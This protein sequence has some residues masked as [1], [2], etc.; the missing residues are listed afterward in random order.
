MEKSAPLLVAN[1]ACSF[2]RIIAIYTVATFI[3]LLVSSQNTLAKPH[4]V[5]P[6]NTYCNPMNLDYAFV[7]YRDYSANNNDHR[8]TADPACVLHDG[9]YYLFSTNQEG[10]WWSDDLTRWHFISHFFKANVTGDQVCAPAVLSTR[11]GLLFLPCRTDV[12]FDSMP[13]YLSKNPRSG[14]WKEEVEQFPVQAW[15]PGLFQDNDGRIYLYWGSSNVYPIYGAELDPNKGYIARGPIHELLKLDPVKHGWERFGEDNINGKMDPFIEGAWMNKFGKRYYLQYAAPGT[16]WNVYGDGVYV[17]EHPLGPFTYQSH[18]PF[19]WKPTGFVRGAGH[20]CTFADKYGNLWHIATMVVNVKYTCERRLGLFPAGVDKDGV[21][22][23]DTAFGDY[24]HFI[25]KKRVDP[26]DNF[27]GWF[28]LSYKKKSWASSGKDMVEKA[29]DEDIKTYWSADNGQPGQY[30]AVDLGKEVDVNAI[31]INYAD[32]GA[33]T[34]GKQLDARHRYQIFH[35]LNGRDWILLVDKSANKKEVPHDY[36]E[37]SSAQRTRFLKIVNVE[38]PTGCFALSDFR[39]FGKAP[40]VQAEP[41]S[42]FTALRDSQD[43]RDLRL[44]WKPT[45]KATCYEVSFG[46][47]Q[48]KLYSSFLVYDKNSYDLHGLNVDSSYFFRIRSVSE[49]GLSQYSSAAFVK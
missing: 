11:R 42:E 16:E 7:P 34:Y 10:Y 35:S 3:A 13:L 5:D 44:S 25:P 32:E 4:V 22:F 21:L 9:L 46:E 40:G 17:A 24:P 31:Q 37:L 26:H 19:S 14:E 8:S 36:V 20:S 45:P 23:S 43:R 49:G 15:D 41:V 39:V 48:D 27:A 30:L 29:F 12:V 6:P 33:S 28:L 47:S 1:S 38:M 18:N 2:G